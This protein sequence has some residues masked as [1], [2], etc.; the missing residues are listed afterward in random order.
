MNIQ[1]LFFFLSR[2][3][4]IQDIERDFRDVIIPSMASN[5]VGTPSNASSPDVSAIPV[6]CAV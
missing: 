1:A 4:F 3:W 6:S 5:V 2:G